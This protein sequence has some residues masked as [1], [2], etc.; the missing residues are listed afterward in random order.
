MLAVKPEHHYCQFVDCR[1]QWRTQPTDIQG[2]LCTIDF[3]APIQSAECE[4]MTAYDGNVNRHAAN[5]SHRNLAVQL[6]M[7]KSAISAS[8]QF[9][10]PTSHQ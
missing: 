6:Y 9:V 2:M 4:G 10:T 1:A 7:Q 5:T 8:Y 3:G